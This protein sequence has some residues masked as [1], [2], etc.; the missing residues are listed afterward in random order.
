M[1]L[2]KLLSHLIMWV[3][4]PL[5][6]FGGAMLF[7]NKQAAWLSVCLALFAC[8]PFFLRFEKQKNNTARL[9]IIAVMVAL[10][11]VGRIATAAL[12]GF[13]PVSAIVLLTAMYFGCE[14]G[15]LTGA[16]SAVISNFYFGQGL[17]TPIQMVCWGMVGL[18]AGLFAKLLKKNGIA[19]I[20][21]GILAGILFSLGM[22]LWTVLW[23][24]GY[25]SWSRYWA[26]AATSAGFTFV[27]AASNVVFLVLLRLPLGAVLER[28]R[29]K[30]KI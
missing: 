2:R 23:Y 28:I 20:V 1:K 21:S 10:S 7:E 5:A 26:V 15:F 29:T 3:V 24:D 18:L 14:A 30:F 13:K 6:A 11:V 12:P 25:F 4:M 19:L 27:Y 17:W 16:L 8:I 9:V 22:D